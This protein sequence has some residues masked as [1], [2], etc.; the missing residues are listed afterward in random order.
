MQ[1]IEATTRGIVILTLLLAASVISASPAFA[2]GPVDKISIAGPGLATP[3]EITNPELL[4]GLDP[5]AA[6]FV[7]WGRGPKAEPP[8]AG[9]HYEVFFYLKEKNADFSLIYA[10]YYSPAPSGKQEY[11][12]LPGPGE[13]WYR[14]N[15]GTIIRDGQDGKWHYAT[16]AWDATMQRVLEEH[17]ASITKPALLASTLAT[18]LRPWTFILVAIG[19]V[20]GVAWVVLL[21]RRQGSA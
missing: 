13:K 15:I 6:M 18:V 8:S 12:Y 14:L 9:K 2:K 11:I 17:A 21:H 7:D 10:L 20:A 3:I 19:L 5:W 1:G 4:R 16:P